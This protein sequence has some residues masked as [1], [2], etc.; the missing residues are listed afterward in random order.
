MELHFSLQDPKRRKAKN[1]RNKNPQGCQRSYLFSFFY[2]F[3]FLLFILFSFFI[4]V[5]FDSMKPWNYI[6][7]CKIQKGER[8]KMLATRIP[9]ECQRSPYL[10]LFVHVVTSLVC[11]LLYFQFI[12][13][14]SHNFHF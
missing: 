8:P 6:L 7:V 12:F 3:L 1:T 4:L 13:Y 10:M 5:C 2:F 14:S 9:Q 11:C